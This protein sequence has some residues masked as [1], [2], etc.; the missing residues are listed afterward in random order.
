MYKWCYKATN[1]FY[2]KNKIR[3]KNQLIIIKSSHGEA[4]TYHLKFKICV[5]YVRS[6]LTFALIKLQTRNFASKC[7][8][9]INC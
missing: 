9:L 7:T 5:N 6:K 3:L 4:G 8:T 2:W 1:F